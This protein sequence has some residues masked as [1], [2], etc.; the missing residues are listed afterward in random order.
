MC[1]F[2]TGQHYNCVDV[3]AAVNTTSNTDCLSSCVSSVY[4]VI[5]ILK[6]H[7][8]GSKVLRGIKNSSTIFLYPTLRETTPLE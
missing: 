5:D 8:I 2:F 3:C 4:C 7:N 6:S 1:C